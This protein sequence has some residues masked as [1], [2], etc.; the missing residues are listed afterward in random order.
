MKQ[1][2]V[3]MKIVIFG[4]GM[5]GQRVAS[6]ALNRGHEV[7]GI[8]RDPARIQFSDPR[9]T[10]V[11]GTL[12]DPEGV[13]Q[14]VTG[15]NVVVN[16]TG[17]R[18]DGSDNPQETYLNNAYSVIEGL[19]QAGV[20]RLLVVGGAGSL[21][22]APGVQLVDTPDFPAAW[23]AGA[24]A[25]RDALVVYRT[26]DLD[27]T[28]LSPAIMIAPGERTGTYRTGTDQVFTDEKGNSSISAEDYAVAMLDEI[29]KPQFVR[30]RF[31]IAY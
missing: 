5:I 20:Q 1:E 13:A 3:N 12:S 10:I 31:T 26:A 22:V 19:K 23:K 15:Y 27:W 28:F 25:L 30:H 24:S 4:L 21:E 8:V 6:E 29:E 11:Q 17:P 18:H 14:A 7:K 9:L 2:V 16:A